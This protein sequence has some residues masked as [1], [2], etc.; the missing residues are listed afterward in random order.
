MGLDAYVNCDCYEAG[1]LREPPPPGCAPTVAEDG[2]LQ[3]GSD[4]LDVQ[5]AFD[6][7]HYFRAC[8][9]EYGQ[10][11]HHYIGNVALVATLRKELERTRDRFPLLLGR[12]LYNGIHAGDFIDVE[13]MPELRRETMAITEINCAEQ[14]TTNYVRC[15]MAQ[16]S[17]L[18]ECAMHSR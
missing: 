18:I 13:K 16:M 11:L 3:C 15:F 12:V 8:E 1:R 10:L 7:W 14:E 5:L 2:G 6:Q 4:E 17:E 9:H